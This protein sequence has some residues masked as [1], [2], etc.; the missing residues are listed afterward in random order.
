MAGWKQFSFSDG[1]AIRQ[2]GGAFPMWRIWQ[3]A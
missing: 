1:E 2:E 3:A